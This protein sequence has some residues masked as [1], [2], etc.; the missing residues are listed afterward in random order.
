M[1]ISFLTSVIPGIEPKIDL[2]GTLE[3]TTVYVYCGIVHPSTTIMQTFSIRKDEDNESIVEIHC[4]RTHLK[5]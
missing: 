3:Q 2:T 1:R 4:T 5:N